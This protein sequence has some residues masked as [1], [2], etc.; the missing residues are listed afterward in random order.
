MSRCPSWS[1][2]L[3]VPGA[4][5]EGSVPV[6]L[7]ARL[8]GDH[9]L[10]TFDSTQPDLNHWLQQHATTADAKGLGRTYVWHRGDNR[11]LAYYT[12]SPHLIRREELPARFGRGG[13]DRIPAILLARLALDRTLHGQGL[14]GELLYDAL[15]T[16]VSAATRV[17]GRYVLVDAID[18]KA[19][20][21][22]LHHGFRTCPVPGRRLVR[23]MS[24]IAKALAAA[25]ESAI[26]S[27]GRARGSS[28]QE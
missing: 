22:Y 24:D 17:G 11:V 1:G 27:P 21:F 5:P 3:P 6:Y 4:S 9:D 2:W 23:K 12:L 25:S 26:P 20:A 18:D 8:T 19:A 13:P 10:S 28:G 16:A 14:G 15:S 7:S